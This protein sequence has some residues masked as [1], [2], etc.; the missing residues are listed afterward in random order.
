MRFEAVLGHGGVN[1][2]TWILYSE[3]RGL[4]MQYAKEQ[5]SDTGR[6]I[7]DD[8]INKYGAAA[9]EK[10]SNWKGGFL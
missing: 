4:S 3:D 10:E 6:R 7:Y 8:E 9:K 5:H 2:W 1:F